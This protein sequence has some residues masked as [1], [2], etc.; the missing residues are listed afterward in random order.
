MVNRGS[1]L[2][3]NFD[4]SDEEDT[5]RLLLIE[6]GKEGGKIEKIKLERM[7]NGIVKRKKSLLA[8]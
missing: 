7:R 8:T 4:G 6:T 1:V 2:S 3:A 5:D